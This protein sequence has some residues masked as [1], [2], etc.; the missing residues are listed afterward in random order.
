MAITKDKLEKL[1]NN[2][3]P[4]LNIRE[5]V[6]IY[7]YKEPK[8]VLQEGRNF[9]VVKEGRKIKSFNDYKNDKDKKEKDN[10]KDTGLIFQKNN[11]TI[12]LEVKDN[13]TDAT[14]STETGSTPA[15]G[16]SNKIKFGLEARHRA[17]SSLLLSPPESDI[18]GDFLRC[19]IFNSIKSSFNLSLICDFGIFKY[20]KAAIIFCSTVKPRKIDGSCGR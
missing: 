12:K 4:K 14:S 16:S 8:I 5:S 11:D 20:S 19:S 17:I 18:E 3:E 2:N 1:F 13:I 7:G 6:E 10:L 9:M 15:N